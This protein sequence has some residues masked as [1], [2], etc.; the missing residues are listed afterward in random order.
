MKTDK[1]IVGYRKLPQ[2]RKEATRKKKRIVFTTGCF[3]LLHLGHVMH[4]SRCC[5]ERGDILVVS[6]GNDKTVRSLKGPTRPIQDERFRARMVAALEC[7]DYVVISREFGKMDHNRI[8][9]LLK[10]DIYVVPT[11]DSH[12]EEKKKLILANGGK[13]VTCRRI[14]RGVSTTRLAQKLGWE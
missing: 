7:V 10:P 1:K 11:T 4:L 2:I 8:V 6:V 13:L 5:K 12:L 3:D 14:K 9:E